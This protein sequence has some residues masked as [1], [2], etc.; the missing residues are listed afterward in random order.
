MQDTDHDA[1]P[2][3][4][5]AAASA[6]ST[7]GER[8]GVS[9]FRF[10]SQIPPYAFRLIDAVSWWKISSSCPL[11]FSTNGWRVEKG[12]RKRGLLLDLCN[13]FKMDS[14]C[15]RFEGISASRDPLYICFLECKNGT[16]VS[17]VDDQAEFSA[18]TGL[19]GKKK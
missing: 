18:L 9:L 4:H 6:P 8:A 16:W 12:K 11:L 13:R 10:P 1:N 19:M 7:I 17:Y 2:P 3:L 15:R 5:V 14:D